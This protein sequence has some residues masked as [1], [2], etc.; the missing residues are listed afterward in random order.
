MKLVVGLGNPGDRYAHTRHNFGFM[1]LDRLVD[2]CGSEFSGEVCH[3][4]TAQCPIGGED[5]LLAKPT[6]YVNRSGL[7]VKC[8]L[9]E[10]DIA[11]RDVI[12]VYDDIALPLGQIRVREMGGAGGHNGVASIVDMIGSIE[13]GRVR[14]GI[15][16]PPDTFC[17]VSRRASCPWSMRCSER[18]YP[19]SSASS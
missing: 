19:R 14:L 7:T 18:Q 10:F 2:E 16:R 17:R 15:G 12:V 4:V 9:S 5:L 13:F 8:M 1:L 11:L 3:A 6:T